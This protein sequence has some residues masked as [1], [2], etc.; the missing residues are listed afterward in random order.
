MPSKKSRL[1]HCPR[2][3]ISTPE[4]K[5]K[6]RIFLN[7]GDDVKSVTILKNATR[8]L[9][10]RN[11]AIGVDG[12][13]KS[14]FCPRSAIV[15]MAEIEEKPK[16]VDIPAGAVVF[17]SETYK[18]GTLP[19]FPPEFVGRAATVILN[20]PEPDAMKACIEQMGEKTEIKKR[21]RKV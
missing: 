1:S 16:Y 8:V 18:A 2:K 4:L 21:K 15:I 10:D 12:Y 6:I 3:S 17:Y 7:P 9:S 11:Q 14:I 20:E 5:N 13:K 19:R